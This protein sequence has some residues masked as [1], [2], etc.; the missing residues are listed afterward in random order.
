MEGEELEMYPHFLGFHRLAFMDCLKAQ[1][2]FGRHQELFYLVILYWNL[3]S[4]LG[5]FS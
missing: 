1:L 2:G 4:V 5:V 3:N